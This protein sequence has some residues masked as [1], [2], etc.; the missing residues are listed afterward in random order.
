MIFQLVR[1]S[2]MQNWLRTN[3]AVHVTSA[4]GN[5]KQAWRL[6]L[7]ANGGTGKSD[8]EIEMNFLR[9][10]GA[11]G[12]SLREMWSSYLSA[13]GQSGSSGSKAMSKY[14]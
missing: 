11:T 7:A 8:N 1:P 12:R 9:T 4:G 13:Q 10:Q 2:N 3:A 5:Y 6:Y 14:K